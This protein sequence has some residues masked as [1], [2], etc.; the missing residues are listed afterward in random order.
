MCERIPGRN[1][2]VGLPIDHKSSVLP[3]VPLVIIEQGSGGW[4]SKLKLNP[5]FH[6]W[7]LL[8]SGQQHPVFKNCYFW[9]VA[10]LWSV[11]STAAVEI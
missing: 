4:S 7:Y 1:G 11:Y 6:A 5:P 2:A 3:A 9:A 10:P 8:L